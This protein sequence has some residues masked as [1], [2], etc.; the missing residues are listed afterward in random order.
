MIHTYHD[1]AHLARHDQQFRD[2][3]RQAVQKIQKVEGRDRQEALVNALRACHYNAGFLLPWFFPNFNGPKDP[4][5][6][7]R[8]PFAFPMYAMLNR[9]FLVIKGSR[10]ISKSTNLSA[11]QLIYTSLLQRVSTYIAPHQEHVR[12]YA[13]KLREMERLF[14]YNVKATGFRNNL[15]F[16]EYKNGSRIELYRVLTSASAMRGKFADELLYDEYQLFDIRL[17]AE[18]RQLQQTSKNPVTIYSGTST[19]IDSPLEARYQQSSGGVWMMRSP[20]G[21]FI[22]CADPEL[23]LKMI[24]PKGLTCP[25]TDRLILDPLDGQLVHARPDLLEQNIVGLHIPQFIIPDFMTPDEWS[26]IWR[27][28]VDFGDTRTLQEVGGVSTEEGFRE[29]TQKDLQDLCSLDYRDSTE[30][31]RAYLAGKLKY[32]FIVSGCDWGGSDYQMSHA[33]KTSYTVH[34]IFGVKGD[35]T[36]DILHMKRYSGMIYDEIASL[37]VRDHLELSGTAIASDFG[38]GLAYNTLLHRDT[39]INPNKHFVW[40]YNAPYSPMIMKPQFQQFP[41][42]YLLNKTESITQLFDALK[43]GRIRCYGWENAQTHLSDILNCQ[44]VHAENRHGRQYFL[45][46]RS[47]SRADDTLHAINFAFVLTRL[48]L[49]EPMFDDMNLRTQ[50]YD[51]LGMGPAV[52]AANEQHTTNMR[53]LV[54]SG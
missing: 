53:H 36:I 1:L 16:K 17:E 9:G 18:I 42:Q 37:I 27:Y 10:R 54:G 47:P 20:G 5:S 31:K 38:A 35:G 23:I 25:Y 14:R 46:I 26:K 6:L 15:E 39:R 34:V 33:A 13:T 7:S 24:R 19:T 22:N 52:Q 50:V 2:G 11:R 44:R 3:M 4:M 21:K 45:H 30:I 51:Q 48:L 29:I 41:T 32:R 43:S 8:R 12:T 49:K 40:A 28:R